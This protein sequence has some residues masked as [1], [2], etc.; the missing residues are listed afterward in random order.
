MFSVMPNAPKLNAYQALCR[1][2]YL[3]LAP[4]QGHLERGPRGWV[5]SC[6][7]TSACFD[8]QMARIRSYKLVRRRSV[9]RLQ[10]G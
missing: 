1:H 3:Q 5:A 10:A 4:G 8:R 9:P 2:C 6:S 7:D